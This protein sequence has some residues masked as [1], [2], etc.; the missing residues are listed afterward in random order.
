VRELN[1][2]LENRLLQA[3]KLETIGKLTSGMA[4]DFS[5]LLSSIF[6]S[7]NLLRKRV[8][9]KEDVTRLIDNIESCS[10]R[11]KDLTKGLLSFGKPTPK[12]KELIKPNM[13]LSEMSK[14]IIQTFPR[15]LPL[16]PM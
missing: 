5:N 14:V 3:Q 10:V 2:N 8:P 13:L 7:L 15:T 12:R 6:G 16:K 9:P 1:T 4:H 11:A